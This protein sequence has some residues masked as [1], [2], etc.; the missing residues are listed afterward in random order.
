MPLNPRYAAVRGRLTRALAVAVVL[1]ITVPVAVVV[2][3]VVG[4]VKR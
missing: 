3:A 4:V 1:A 2:E